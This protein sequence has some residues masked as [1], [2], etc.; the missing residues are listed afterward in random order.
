[1]PYEL[2]VDPALV[3]T[4]HADYIVKVFVQY[5]TTVASQLKRSRV[6]AG[7]PSSLKAGPV[8]KHNNL[9]ILVKFEDAL[10]AGDRIE[11]NFDIRIL[12]ASKHRKNMLLARD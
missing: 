11:R 7:N 4:T 6:S 5:N 1:M 12:P 8:V 9:L 2:E 10:L 3:R